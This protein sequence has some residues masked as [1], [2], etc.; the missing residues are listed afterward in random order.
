MKRKFLK[1]AFIGLCLV[2]LNVFAQVPTPLE[3]DLATALRIA[4]D[5]N[6]TIKVAE[7]EIQRVD[8][9]R[10]E[11]I[12]NLLPNL[13]AVGQY[14]DNVMKQVMFMPE[15]FAALME[16]QKYMEIGYKNSFV[17][18]VNAQIPI[19]NF[20]IWQNIK[21]KQN[22]IDIIIEKS[23][24]SK[25]EMTKQVKDAYYTVL[26]S[27]SSLKVLQQSHTNALETLKNIENS[28]KQGIVSEYDYIRAQVNV[29]N[30]NPMLINA[31]NGVELSIMQLRMILS[32]PPEQ[33]III[34]EDLDSF[35]D[36]I[37][38]LTEVN[39][40]SILAQNSDLKLLDYNILGLKNQL[41]VINTQHLPML[42]ANGSYIYQTQAENFKF[43][44][45]TWIGSAS[46][47]LQLTVPLFAGMTKVN[48][49]KQVEMAIK[50]LEIQREYAKDG[51]NL[52]VKAAI[53]SMNAAKEQLI[54]NKDAIKQAQRGYEIAK[55]RYQVG[56]GTILELNDSELSLTQASLNLQQSLFNFLSSQANLE[57]VM[58]SQQ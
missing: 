26:L 5:N 40:N 50:G 7:I 48:Q 32:L 16:G 3:L 31:K 43:K 20:T 24:S 58:G 27:K 8:Y 25:I 19:I 11:A 33:N 36:N 12:G 14:T 6:P 30:L 9:A 21:N 22:D 37:N 29:N 57:K 38:I 49:A 47:G 39:N 34:K 52:Q 51:L 45:Y 54:V 46:V 56:S 41:K 55:V 53:N 2:N 28:Y 4:H 35:N 18:S 44:D 23:R 1:L 10:K 42:S 15:S 13:N 17:G